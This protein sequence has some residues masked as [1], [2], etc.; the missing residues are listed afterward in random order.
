MSKP[1]TVVDPTTGTHLTLSPDEMI[2]MKISPSKVTLIPKG[3][4]QI[5]TMNP[6]S[7]L[8]T[9][10]SDIWNAYPVKP[11]TVDA[12]KVTQ[13]NLRSI[14]STL[15]GSEVGVAVRVHRDKITT[16]HIFSLAVGDWLIREWDY[17]QD[18]AT[19]RKA[20]F[21]ERKKYDLR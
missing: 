12:I 13:D 5:T 16:D 11:D 18:R 3:T 1:H 15:L 9:P 20:T 7:Y 2:A 4:G 21:S 14:G 8:A 19:Y 6:N 10:A 17:E